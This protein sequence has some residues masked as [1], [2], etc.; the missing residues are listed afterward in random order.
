[1]GSLYLYLFTPLF[2]IFASDASL[3]PSP[4][5]SSF[6]CSEG[7]C[8]GNEIFYRLDVLSSTLPSP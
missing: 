3:T 1:M 6:T 5:R 2:T 8:P 7:G 4:L